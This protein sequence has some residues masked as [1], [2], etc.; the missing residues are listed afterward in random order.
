L[1]RAFGFNLSGS[2]SA[3]CTE[4]LSLN[5]EN[6]IKRDEDRITKY[7]L[8]PG[9][10]R[11]S[12]FPGQNYNGH[13]FY[14]YSIPGVSELGYI[15]ST[16]PSFSTPIN[17]WPGQSLDNHFS[18]WDR[19]TTW[20]VR[21]AS[22][23][24]S[25]HAKLVKIIS[26]TFPAT[27]PTVLSFDAGYGY[28]FYDRTYRGYG[29]Y[30]SYDA[31]ASATFRMN[32]TIHTVNATCT[33]PSFPTVELPFLMANQFSGQTA[34]EVGFELEFKNCPPHMTAIRYMAE[35]SGGVS[36]GPSLGLLPLTTGSSASGIAVQVLQGTTGNT[37]VQLNQWATVSQYNHNT[38]NPQNVILPFRAR[39]YKTAANWQGG[40][41]KAAMIVH[42]KY[43]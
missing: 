13:Y 9:Q 41:I 3:T 25:I 36:P 19:T 34:G 21:R 16:D 12:V 4:G 33:T 42:I 6:S 30:G 1:G 37:P 5:L 17:L 40:K 35:A 32:I 7:Q 14:V 38:S 2:V 31:T 10:T 18:R 28:Q 11:S 8:A 23:G 26:G 29:F 15:M 24:V 27:L 22:A 39:Y 43:Q 20:V